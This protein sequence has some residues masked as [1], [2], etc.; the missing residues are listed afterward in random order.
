MESKSTTTRARSLTQGVEPRG[1]RWCKWWAQWM[2]L[3]EGAVPSSHIRSDCHEVEMNHNNSSRAMLTRGWSQG[4]GLQGGRVGRGSQGM[5]LVGEGSHGG[6]S[7]GC[8]TRGV[9]RDRVGPSGKGQMGISASP[10]QPPQL[11]GWGLQV[12]REMMGAGEGVGGGRGCCIPVP[13]Q[14]RL[15]RSQVHP[16][17]YSGPKL[18]GGTRVGA[19]GWE[20]LRAH[21][22]RVPTKFICQEEDPTTTTT[23]RSLTEGWSQG[24]VPPGWGRGFGG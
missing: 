20:S 18:K 5:G 13:H 24:L 6:W 16:P 14:A 2:G 15:S 4:L 1:L 23:Q 21:R 11:R 19:P 17:Q 8:R 12:G 7:Q 22:G 10:P 9:G 3:V